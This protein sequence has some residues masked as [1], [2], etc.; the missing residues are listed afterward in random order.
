MGGKELL[1]IWRGKVSPVSCMVAKDVDEVRKICG[2]EWGC[3]WR[4]GRVRTVGDDI[5]GKPLCLDRAPRLSIFVIE[6]IGEEEDG[7]WSPT[8]SFSFYGKLS[9]RL[10]VISQC[11][12]PPPCATVP[13]F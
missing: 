8:F 4:S 1:W 5:V 11:P 12:P 7:G 3:G 6:C 2:H 10:N 13:P 9:N